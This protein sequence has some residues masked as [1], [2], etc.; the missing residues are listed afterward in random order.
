V[1][2]KNQ[3]HGHSHGHSHAITREGNSKALA[4]AFG[5]TGFIMVAEAAGGW[6]TNSLA[7]MS[8]AGHM[9]SDAASLGLSLLAI[10]FSS[11]A[12]SPSKSYGYLRLEILAALANG[13]ALFVI[14][15]AIAW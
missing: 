12:A 4:W 13:A 7:L 8:D 1:S 9:L 3:N 14:A 2:E 5:I 6:L 10:R 11:R 15:I